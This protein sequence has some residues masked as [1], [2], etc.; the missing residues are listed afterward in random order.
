MTTMDRRAFLARSAAA[1]SG[2]V[3]GTEALARL[4]NRAALADLR[5]RGR[6]YGPLKRKRDQHGRFVLALPAGFSYVTFGEIGSTMSDGRPTPLALDGMAAFK[7]PRRT[8]RLIRNSE[9]RNVPPNPG[10]I[11]AGPGAY[12]PLAGGGTTT[13]DYDPRTRRLVRSFVSLEG[14]TINCAGGFGLDRRSWLTGEETIY[15]PSRGFSQ[16]HGYLF[17]VPVNRGRGDAPH[18]QPLKAMGR[19]MHEAAA[20]D[21]RTGIVYET[22]DPGSGRGAGFYRFIPHNKR[23]LA[24]GGKLQILAIKGKD[25]YDAREGQR[26]GRKLPVRWITIPTPDPEYVNEDD[27]NGTFMQGWNRGAAKFNRLEGCWYADGS[28]F[29]VS[30]SGG[31]EKSP[32]PPNA[33]GYQEG[34]GQVWEYRI[35]TRQLILHYESP[36]GEVLDSPDN[37]TVTPRGGIMVCEDDASDTDTADP[38]R[39]IGIGPN[40]RAFPFAECIFSSSE[41]AGVC[42]SPDGDTMFVNLFGD[43]T[44]TPATHAGKGM[45][46]AITGPWKRGPL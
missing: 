5:P 18:S 23:R 42:F 38:N 30:T 7:G 4:S 28:V 41:L 29:F 36:G 14:T 32:D 44:G 33:D 21:Q 45:T 8:V 31:D 9:D 6:G 25:Q 2:S 13:L 22:E 10:G 17:E 43:S 15:G 35:R 20:T 12:D 37:L 24:A 16:P 1:A 3:V 11:T 40:G 26:P 34:Y 39:V 27:P 19:F 46:C